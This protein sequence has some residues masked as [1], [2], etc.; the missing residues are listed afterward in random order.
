MSSASNETS[1]ELG[2]LQQGAFTYQYIEGLKGGADANGDKIITISELYEYVSK[3]V[4]QSTYGHQ[5]PQLKG[6]FDH[7][8]PVGVTK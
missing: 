3:K 4:T 5:H 2:T 1:L 8:M 7:D 6:I